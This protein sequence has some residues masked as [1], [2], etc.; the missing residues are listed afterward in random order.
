MDWGVC[1]CVR[2]CEKKFVWI[3]R[4]NTHKTSPHKHNTYL[5]DLLRCYLEKSLDLIAVAVFDCMRFEGIGAHF[6]S[7]E[8]AFVNDHCGAKQ[9]NTHTHTNGNQTEFDSGRPVFHGQDDQAKTKPAGWMSDG[10]AC[11]CARTTDLQQKY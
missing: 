3:E 1:V 9:N 2:L 10:H 8:S 11:L 7:G 4:T 6:V 5:V